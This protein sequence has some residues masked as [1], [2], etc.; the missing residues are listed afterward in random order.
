MAA[1][2]FDELACA[3]TFVIAYQTYGCK[4]S[5]CYNHDAETNCVFFCL[6]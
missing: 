2:Q 5:I 4:S 1:L 6:N 3:E